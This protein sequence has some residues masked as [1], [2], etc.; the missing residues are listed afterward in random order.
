VLDDLP[1]R[2]LAETQHGLVTRGQLREAGLTDDQIRRLVDD[3]RW[4]WMTSQVARLVGSPRTT[5]QLARAAAFDA[6]SQGALVGESA[7]AWWGIPGNQLEPLQVVRTRGSTSRLPT[8]G[9]GHE[10]VLLPPHHVVVLDGVPVVVPARAL[11]DIAG[12][13]RGGAELPWWHQRMARMVDNAWNLRLVSGRT[14]HRM[15]DEMATR[16]RPGIRVM[17]AVLQPRG[18]DYIPPASNA[19]ARF[20]DILTSAGL[21]AMRRQVNSG[22]D[23]SWIGRVDFRDHELP[24]IVEI[25]SE[26]FHS[27]L[28]DQQLDALRI[29]RLERAG[30][31]VVQITDVQLWHRRHEVVRSV[32]DGRQ[33]ARLRQRAAG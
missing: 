4:C 14:L 15:L 7:A 31:V 3:R 28:I 9:V 20:E 24:L 2:R 27:S 5:E 32:R 1:L 6:G 12:S 26:R 22:D 16:G 33:L 29:E 10:P 25:Q 11:F 18:L 30:F 19:E 13:K 17:R 8:I 21:P 23:M